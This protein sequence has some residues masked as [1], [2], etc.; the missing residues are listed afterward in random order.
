MIREKT[1]KPATI[2]RGVFMR[3]VV[4][5]IKN[6]KAAILDDRG[7][8]YAIKDRGYSVGQVLGLSELEIRKERVKVP[9]RDGISAFT[10]AAAA[11]IA[12]AIQKP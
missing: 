6:N 3:S 5:E 7:I 4:L 11:I 9:I 8:V 12:P 2:E 10:R 1:L